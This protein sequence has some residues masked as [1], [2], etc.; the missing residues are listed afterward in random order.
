MVLRPLKRG[1][2]LMVNHT[3]AFKEPKPFCS[4][5]QVSLRIEANWRSNWRLNI[6]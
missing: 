2:Q 6:E 4:Y 5:M 1:M 3:L